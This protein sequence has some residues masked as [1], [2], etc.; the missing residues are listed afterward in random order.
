MP[1][2]EDPI[3]ILLPGPRIN[4]EEAQALEHLIEEN[5]VSRQAHIILDLAN[6]EWMDSFLLGS[7]VSMQSMVQ[8]KGGKLVLCNV[9]ET[10]LGLL[11]LM[12]L[13][14]HFAILGSVNEATEY[15]HGEE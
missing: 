1:P 9:S 6:L 4:S 7:L 3:V 8:K 2:S 10:V 14:P 11:R 15:L 5:L 13:D 12:R